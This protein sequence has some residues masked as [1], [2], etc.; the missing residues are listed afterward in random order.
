MSRG[1]RL[2]ELLEAVHA[3]RA[4]GRISPAVETLVTGIAR[5]CGAAPVE[6]RV[7]DVARVVNL[8]ER[9]AYKA[10]P[11]ARAYELI[12]RDEVEGSRSFAY[13]IHSRFAERRSKG[14]A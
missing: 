7:A 1:V 14:A 11:Q 12:A 2:H 9:G 10:I 3:L 6:M 8:S 5:H 13:R 4:E